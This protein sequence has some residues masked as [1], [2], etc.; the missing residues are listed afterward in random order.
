MRGSLIQEIFRVVNEIHG[1][2]TKKN[3]EWQE[4]LPV[5]VLKAEEIIYSKANSEEEY[6]DP[7]TLWDRTND[8]INTIIRREESTETGDLLQPCIEA[9]LVLGCTVRRA[10]RSQRNNHPRAYLTPITQEPTPVS[11]RV[12]VNITHG[13]SSLR[14]A[15]SVKPTFSSHIVGSP[16]T[17]DNKPTVTHTFPFPL[18]NLSPSAS[19]QVSFGIH[20]SANVGRVYP[21][22]FGAHYQATDPQVVSHPPQGI[23]S[24]EA[25]HG[26]SQC[27]SI[28]RLTEKGF[29]QNFFMC[30]AV[31]NASNRDT[32]AEWRRSA[33]NSPVIECDLSLRLGPLSVP[34]ASEETGCAHE[35]V[36]IG[37]SS[38]QEWDK[39]CDQS[40]R[41]SKEFC[42]FPRDSADDPLESSS[43][44]W[45]SKGRGEDHHG[46]SRKHKAPVSYLAESAHLSYHCKYSSDQFFGRMK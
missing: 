43:S 37:S 28:R 1:T 22:Y 35:V 26:I 4:K 27:Q 36:D 17:V 10:S 41:T 45:S 12:A 44:K 39:S 38:S 19:N 24:S 15:H 7:Q 11:S 13:G 20:P 2:E 21:L 23:N 40:P 14:P 16:H 32:E 29:L 34:C 18:E 42:F 46:S 30:D 33:E 25:V 6:L 8:A 9:A 5:V 3:K 31:V